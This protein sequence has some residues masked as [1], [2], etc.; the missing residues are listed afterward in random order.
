[1]KTSL[2]LGGTTKPTPK[3]RTK[4]EEPSSSAQGTADD[5]DQDATPDATDN[6]PLTFNPDQFDSD[7]DSSGGGGKAPSSINGI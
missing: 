4:G 1:M 5:D 2:V 7:S 6:C 3:Q